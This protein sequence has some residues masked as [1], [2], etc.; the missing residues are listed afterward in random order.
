MLRATLLALVLFAAPASAG[1]TLRVSGDWGGE[2][3]QRVARIAQMERD[4]T[5]VVVSGVCASACTLYLK[6][7]TTCLTAGARL[8]FH[9]PQTDQGFMPLDTFTRYQSLMAAHYPPRM[10]RWFVGGPGAGMDGEAWLT[11]KQAIAMGA[12]AC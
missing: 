9:G 3:D 11:A 6:L 10:A 12:R 1:G 8:G 5:R 4:G 2:V 7:P